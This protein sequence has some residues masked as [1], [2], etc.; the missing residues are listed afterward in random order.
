MEQ[1]IGAHSVMPEYAFL[2]HI[3]LSRGVAHLCEPSDKVAH[4]LTQA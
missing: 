4:Q 3:E 1:A 2:P